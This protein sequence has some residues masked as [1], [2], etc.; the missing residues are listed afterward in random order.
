MNTTKKTI[1]IKI[2]TKEPFN[3]EKYL[4]IMLNSFVLYLGERNARNDLGPLCNT[5]EYHTVYG[6]LHWDLQNEI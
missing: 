2:E 6:I 5:G 3:G 1:S 4:P